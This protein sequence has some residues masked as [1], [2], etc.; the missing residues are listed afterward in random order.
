M[1]PNTHESLFLKGKH[2]MNRMSTLL[3]TERLVLRTYEVEDAPRLAQ[4]AGCKDVSD[5]MISVPYPYS[6][7]QAWLDITGFARAFDKRTDFHFAIA[8]KNDVRNFV[9][10]IA[11]RDVDW[12]HLQGELSFWLSSQ[13]RGH[14]YITEA[15]KP[16]LA[17]SF[18]QL[19]LNRICAYHMKRNPASGKVLGRL[20]FT[21]EGCLR[22]RVRKAEAYE[23]ACVWARLRQDL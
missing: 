13:H 20:G 4:L 10:H 3:S 12:E 1:L 2:D 11:L 19:G 5:T 8:P 7:E 14:G 15:G 17:L 6:T 16:I 18:G 9:G 22:Q 23:D 21:Y